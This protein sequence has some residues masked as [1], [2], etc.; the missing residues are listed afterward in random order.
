MHDGK[1]QLLQIL[2]Y[3]AAVVDGLCP[4]LGLLPVAPADCGWQMSISS[5][6][7][8][9][10]WLPLW[11]EKP[12]SPGDAMFSGMSLSGLRALPRADCLQFAFHDRNNLLMPVYH[13]RPIV[14]RGHDRSLWQWAR[15]L[16]TDRLR[17][18]P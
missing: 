9:D 7:L 15:V 13:L 16:G 1:K 4:R 17:L 11:N 18:L 3:F 12:A 8:T 14:L 6:C 10:T 2:G 5:P